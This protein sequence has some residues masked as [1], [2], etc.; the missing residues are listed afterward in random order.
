M[1]GRSILAAKNGEEG[2]DLTETL[3]QNMLE[4]I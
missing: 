1:C 4:N 2:I 3:R